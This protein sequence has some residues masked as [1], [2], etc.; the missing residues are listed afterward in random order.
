MEKDYSYHLNILEQL[1][2]KP[3]FLWSE[4]Y[5]RF[6][7]TRTQQVVNEKHHIVPSELIDNEINLIGLTYREH[8]I[9]HLILY[10][11]Y[12][13]SRKMVAATYLLG[14][15]ICV[16]S[17]AFSRLREQFIKAQSEYTKSTIHL[18]KDKISNSVKALWQDEDYSAKMHKHLQ[19]LHARKDYPDL[20]R[21]GLQKQSPEQK[22]ARAKIGAAALRKD[23]DWARNHSE[24]LKKTFS[25]PE[26]RAEMSKAFYKSLLSPLVQ[27]NRK[28][29]YLKS[30]LTWLNK[31]LQRP[32]DPDER[33]KSLELKQDLERQ[34]N[35]AYP[36]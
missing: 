4:R 3:D 6:L 8:Y 21:K 28:I 19:K 7:E 5:K 27:K 11:M 24:K 30:R 16:S 12:P 13:T 20:I 26:R 17:R 36:S 35:D 32:L 1:L 29:G 31:K 25:T 2:G 14:L 15:R 33:I 22:T 18:Y 34:L 9:A 23:P 10:K